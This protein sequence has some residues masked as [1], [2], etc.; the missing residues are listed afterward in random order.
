MGHSQPS[1]APS[2]ARHASRHFTHD[3]AV[4]WTPSGEEIKASLWAALEADLDEGLLSLF[5]P[6][7]CLYVE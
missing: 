5:L 3:V 6:H 1:D 7:S 2:L 4:I